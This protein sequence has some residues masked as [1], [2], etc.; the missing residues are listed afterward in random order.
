M[1]THVESPVG[2]YD[3]RKGFYVENRAC[4]GVVYI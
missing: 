1:F 4:F 3:G 2:S